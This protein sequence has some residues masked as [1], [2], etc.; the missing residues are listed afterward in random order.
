MIKEFKLFEKE[1]TVNLKELLAYLDIKHD[2]ILN[3]S[4]S[5]TNYLT[6]QIVKKYNKLNNAPT[7][8]NQKY[9]LF[10]FDNPM[11]KTIYKE[12]MELT[13][14]ACSY[15][16]YN[17]IEQEYVI[18]GWFNADSPSSQEHDPRTN[19]RLFHDHLGGLGAPDF[20][21]YYC[22]NAEPSSTYYK[23]DEETIFEN[24]NKN[25]RLILCQNGFPHGRGNWNG[26]DQRIT[27]AYDI[28]PKVR[29]KELD[30]NNPVWIDFI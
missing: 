9:N 5:E 29:L 30:I 28:I 23:I 10:Q 2:E 1:L 11:V 3:N 15:Y 4:L 12:L 27:I 26:C 8:L 22:V 6:D 25:N 20:H 24:I 17:F 21:G 13:V 18:R 19:G 16:G 14:T 7:K